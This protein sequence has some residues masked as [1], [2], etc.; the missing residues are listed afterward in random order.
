MYFEKSLC[1]SLANSS[2][3]SDLK[4]SK[5]YFIPSSLFTLAVHPK[6]SLAFVISGC[7]CIGSFIGKSL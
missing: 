6:I 2:G 1:S 4:Y 5:V 3:E 7:R